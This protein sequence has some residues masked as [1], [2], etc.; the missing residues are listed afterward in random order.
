LEIAF[1]SHNNFEG[2]AVSVYSSSKFLTVWLELI[3]GGTPSASGFT[4][5]LLP[6]LSYL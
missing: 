5:C 3:V 2:G 1:L 4:F 6:F